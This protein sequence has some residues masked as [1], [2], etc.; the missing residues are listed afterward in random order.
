GAMSSPTVSAMLANTFNC[1]NSANNTCALMPMR[2]ARSRTTTGGFIWMT[3][4]PLPSTTN[5][6]PTGATIAGAVLVAGMTVGLTTGFGATGAGAGAGF[7]TVTVAL[8]TGDGTWAWATTGTAAG[9]GFG[10]GTTG[11]G[12]ATGGG[13]AGGGGG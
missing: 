5:A 8:A 2:W 10:A 3:L 1:I 7:A 4:L 6:G 11:F 13:G 12:A 9:G